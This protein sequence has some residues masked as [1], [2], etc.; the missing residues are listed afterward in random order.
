MKPT[1]VLV[2]PAFADGSIWSKVIVALQGR[3]YTVVAPQIPMTSVSDDAAALRRAIE[4]VKGPVILAAHSYA[5]AVITKA[6]EDLAQVQG[7]VYIAAMAPAS[8]ETVGEL[9][10][11][12]APHPMGPVLAPDAYGMIWMS[13]DGFAQAVA[14]DASPTE[15]D[16]MTATQKP[17]SVAAIMEP[18]T[19][20]AWAVKPSWFLVATK[21]RVIAAETQ[22]FMA[23]RM[24]ASV[25]EAEVDHSPL[26]SAPEWVVKL[27][28]QA[29][30]GTA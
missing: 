17:I 29:V 12:A 6:A 28:E 15:L 24:K 7:L 2:H 25:I 13:R 4:R 30:E 23:E 3:G 8:G 20:P 27:I 11:R 14:P 1:I 9:L 21:D 5:G 10:H 26:V 16:L 22:R 18:M 19:E